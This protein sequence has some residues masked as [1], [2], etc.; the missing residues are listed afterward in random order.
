MSFLREPPPRLSYPVNVPKPAPTQELDMRSLSA[1]PS[2]VALTQGMK[3]GN[4]YSMF[5][6]A[7]IARRNIHELAPVLRVMQRAG[8]IEAG[9]FTH[10][11]GVVYF[12]VKEKKNGRA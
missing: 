7:G 9:R 6:L 4:N 5:D 11:S 2:V 10:G 8:M 12:R 1:N 3:P